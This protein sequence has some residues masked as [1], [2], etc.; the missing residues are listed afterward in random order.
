MQEGKLIDIEQENLNIKNN[1]K[2]E[3]KKYVTLKI[4]SN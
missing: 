4:Y 1:V 2:E 3:V